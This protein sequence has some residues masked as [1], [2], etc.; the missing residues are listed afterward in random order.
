MALT[1]FHLRLTQMGRLTMATPGDLV[2]VTAAA[3]QIGEGTVAQF[4][5]QLAEGGFRTKG[6]RGRSAA[7]VLPADAANLLISIAASPISGPA[8]KEAAKTCSAYASLRVATLPST[9]EPFGQFGLPRL[10]N[11]PAHHTFGFALGELISA[12]SRGEEICY[13][14]GRNLVPF[15]SLL[16]VTFCG[17][18]PWAEIIADSS[19]GEMKRGEVGRLVYNMEATLGKRKAR[20]IND[21]SDLQQQRYVTFK[22]IRTLA[23]LFA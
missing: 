1:L 13:R 14:D 12:A 6:G 23:S 11:L 4:D 19:I 15:D 8:V 9:S 17:P 3:L 20:K 2:R 18:R 7:R 21:T 16:G 22:T 5:R 10:A